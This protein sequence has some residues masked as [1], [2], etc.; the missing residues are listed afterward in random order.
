[1]T[2]LCFCD[3]VASS[4]FAFA[5]SRASVGPMQVLHITNLAVGNTSFGYLE[6]NNDFRH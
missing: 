6:G 4:C 1:M 5:V 3:N 2:W